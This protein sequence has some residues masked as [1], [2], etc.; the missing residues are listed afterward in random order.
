VTGSGRGGTDSSPAAG[1]RAASILHVDMDAFFVAVELLERPDL[2]G[3]P[4]VVGG[5]LERGVVASASYEARAYGIRSAMPSS[6][7]RRACPH[8]VF[9]P[10]RF[11]VYA[12]FSR[13]MHA[14]F[15]EVTP[16]VE[17]VALDEAYLD[18]GGARRLLGDGATIA[19]GLRRRIAEELHLSCS[20]GVATNKLVAKLASEAAKP[21]ASV[22]GPVPGRGVV[23][24][25]PGE[26][27]R[28]LHPH[29]VEAIPGVG[30]ATLARLR[31][32]GVNTVGDLA[33]VPLDVLQGALGASAGRSLYHL[34]RGEDDRAVVAGRPAKSVGH[35]ETYRRDL[36]DRDE[37]ARQIVRMSDAVA[38]RLRRQGLVA[39]TVTLKV[40]F[41]DWRTITRSQTL[42]VGVRTGP[43]LARTAQRLLSEVEV[44]AGVRLLGVSASSLSTPEEG[45]GEQ[46]SFTLVGD[47]S[48]SLA[49]GPA[50]G[51]W[52]AASRALDAVRDRFG[53][54]AVGPVA[55]LRPDEGS[56]TGR[57]RPD[58]SARPGRS[59]LRPKR[60][61][62]TQWG[63]EDSAPG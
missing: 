2:V 62:D 41:A 25:Q 56:G 61:G 37:M 5:S 4:V 1:G 51:D 16:L 49:S 60:T 38:G 35:E 13:R 45:P 44:D 40:R 7:A 26:V 42:P 52:A 19:K 59:Q 28:F 30:P 22:R 27:L 39:R 34:A 55:L 57:A 50:A 15:A 8:A 21:K 6:Q 63:P 58:G 43:E 29:P 53:D 17:G 47:P 54:A 3:M 10:G 24:V 12:A 36:D 48:P 20:V 33:A 23:V 18:V 31:R 32:L 46:L 9:L 11:E 14:I